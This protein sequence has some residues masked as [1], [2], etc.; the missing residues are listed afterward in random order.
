MVPYIVPTSRWPFW[1][2]SALD[3]TCTLEVKS[4]ME[5]VVLEIQQE[6]SKSFKDSEPTTLRALAHELEESDILDFTL[7]CHEFARKPMDQG[8]LN[9]WN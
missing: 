1:S 4:D 6:G 7:C 5:L 8:W 2:G 9:P 3:H